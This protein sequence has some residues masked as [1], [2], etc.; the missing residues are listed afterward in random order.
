M[1]FDD[2]RLNSGVPV[3]LADEKNQALVSHGGLLDESRLSIGVK[4]WLAGQ[5][6]ANHCC[7]EA[8]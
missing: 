8:C 4:A 3:R 2:Y 7:M 5:K 6:Q 1:V